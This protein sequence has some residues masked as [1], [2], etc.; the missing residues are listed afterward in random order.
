[1]SKKNDLSKLV[2]TP[3]EKEDRNAS[4]DLPGWPG[5]RTRE[6]RSGYDPIDTRNEAAHTAGAFIQNLFTGQ[7][8]IR[9]PVLLFL[10]GILGLALSAPFFLAISE[11]ING[12]LPSWDAWLTMV[13]AAIVGL[14]F[15][16]NFVKN[17]IKS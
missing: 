10:A 4:N 13:I 11:T 7:L 17:L 9:N 6:G 2:K 1:M 3:R 16:I 5:Y 14:S 15:L 8:R 12:N